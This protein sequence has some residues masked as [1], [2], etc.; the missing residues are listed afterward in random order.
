MQKIIIALLTHNRK[1]Q[2]A[3]RIEKIAKEIQFHDFCTLL[4]IENPS[5]MTLDRKEIPIQSNVKYYLKSRNQGLDRSIIQASCFAKHTGSRVWFICDDDDI[6]YDR[7][8]Q[9]LNALRKVT[10]SVCYVP[11]VQTDGKVYDAITPEDAYKR[12]SFL[13]CVCLNPNKVIFS[14]LYHLIG[15]NYVHIAL[16]NQ[17]LRNDNRLHLLKVEAGI[18]ERNKNTR[19]PIFET[20]VSGYLEVLQ[21]SPFLSRRQ[22]EQLVF[23]R[24]Y[25]SLSFL[26]S[27]KADFK[28]LLKSI[29]FVS[30]LKAIKLSQKAKFILKGGYKFLF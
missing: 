18:Q 8:D 19:F 4:I 26:K 21:Y 25:A 28:V 9:I 23:K 17:L 1:E 30:K 7:I 20:F 22:I 11:W 12:M 16:I 14:K 2:A 13:P 5:P 24:S 3:D 29:N 15:T 6:F 10:N 27:N